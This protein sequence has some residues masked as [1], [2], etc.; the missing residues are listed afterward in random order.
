MGAIPVVLTHHLTPSVFILV[1]L[2]LQQRNGQ[3][4]KEG[5][6]VKLDPVWSDGQLS[7]ALQ[8][9]LDALTLA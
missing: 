5:P 2:S 4:E 8:G 9:V 7:G 3:W 1:F 6:C